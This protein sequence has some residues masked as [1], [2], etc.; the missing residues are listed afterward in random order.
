MIAKVRLERDDAYFK[1]A[2][3]A[4]L[5]HRSKNRKH[6]V[7]IALGLLTVS[8]V[9]LTVG[10]AKPLAYGAIAGTTG[11]LIDVGTYAWRWRRK[12]KSM[13]FTEWVELGFDESTIH[14]RSPIGIDKLPYD[15]FQR[16]EA[17]PLGFFLVNDSG[18]SLFVPLA[19]VDPPEKL[20]D[21]IRHVSSK[22]P[23]V[24]HTD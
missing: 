16:M 10:I 17:T 22:L 8:C 11:L 1:L 13:G 14:Y 6:A 4:W 3:R 12:I 7:P 5:K 18:G 24:T 2:Y 19:T 15:A 9:L 21:L 23:T 20:P